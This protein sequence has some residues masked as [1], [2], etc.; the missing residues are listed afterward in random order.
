[1]NPPKCKLVKESSRY[2]KKVVRSI[3]YN[4]GEL[5]VHIQGENFSYARVIF[6]DPVGFRV[7]D[8]RDLLEFWPTYSEPNG[9]LYEVESGGWIELEMMRDGLV[10]KSFMP[11]IKEYFLV[12]DK[13]IS[14]ICIE[15]PEIHDL[16]RD[17]T[18]V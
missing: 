7:L 16:G 6:K 10:S 17:P 15:P 12:D 3:Q 4:W 14:V 5:I 11:K 1:M 2:K 8:E 18:R 9:W 13:C